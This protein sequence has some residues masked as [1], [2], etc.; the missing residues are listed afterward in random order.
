MIVHGFAGKLPTLGDFVHRGWSGSTCD[1]LD[2]LLQRALAALRNSAAQARQAIAQAP[3]LVLSI[4]P[5][6]IGAHGFVGVVLAS[7]DRVGR[8][9]PLCAGVQF[10]AAAI[11][12]LGWP[13]LVYAHAV[14][15]QV[16]SGIDTQAEPDA[17]LAR[18]TAIGDPRDFRPAL[19]APG[20]AAALPVICARHAASDLLGM[21]LDDYGAVNDY[22]ACRR[23]QVATAGPA[24]AAL[25][26]GEWFARGWT[27]FDALGAETLNSSVKPT[28]PPAVSPTGTIDAAFH[29]VN[30]FDTL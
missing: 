25:F 5:G 13:S 9:F 26:D 12:V 8:T 7:H 29:V 14:I 4:R 3:C 15:E 22:F 10:D 21:R 23:L 6:V 16:L 17:L 19:L 1:G 27:S 24:L 11:G 20:L 30:S 28:V 2:A 18:I